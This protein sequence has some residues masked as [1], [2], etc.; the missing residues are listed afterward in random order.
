MKIHQFFQVSLSLTLLF[1]QSCAFIQKNKIRQLNNIEFTDSHNILNGDPIQ[2]NGHTDS[3]STIDFNHDGTRLISGSFDNTIKLWDV[4]SLKEIKTF[5]GHTNKVISIDFASNE[6]TFVSASHDSSIKIWSI[7]RTN[8]DVSIKRNNISHPFN[9]ALDPTNTFIALT[10]LRQQI[11]LFSSKDEEVIKS[12]QAV[13]F[14][15]YS[16]S[17]GSNGKYLA[18]GFLEGPIKIWNTFKNVHEP[19]LALEGHLGNVLSMHWSPNGKYLASSST[20]DGI[21]RIWEIDEKQRKLKKIATNILSGHTKSTKSVHF[22]PDSKYLASG[23]SDK[24]VRIWEV[25]SKK[26]I[27]ILKGHRDI[28]YSVAWSPQGNQ[29][30]SASKDKTIILWPLKPSEEY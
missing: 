4:S 2:L 18:V 19:D 8:E 12:F 14:N 20:A 5:T 24:T 27:S 28:V 26:T 30:A 1:F 3:V 21:I 13:N 22:S 6:N 16:I 17:W 25:K 29:I 9:I 10:S 11:H 15:P 23:S 7:E